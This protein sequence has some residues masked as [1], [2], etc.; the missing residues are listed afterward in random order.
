MKPSKQD[1]PNFHGGPRPT[2]LSPPKRGRQ[3]L[4]SPLAPLLFLI[5]FLPGLPA[6]A[7]ATM[8]QTIFGDLTPTVS[9]SD[10]PR[11]LGLRFSS[12]VAGQISAIRFYRA[13][14][15]CDTGAHTGYLYNAFGTQLAS[16]AIP[17]SN[18]TGWQEQALTTPVSITP[19]TVYVVAVDEFGCYGATTNSGLP[20][21]NGN[22]TGIQGVFSDSPSAFPATV[23]GNN[24]NYFRDV[25]FTPEV[26]ATGPCIDL[27]KAVSVNGPGGPFVR[28][29][30]TSVNPDMNAANPLI[31]SIPGTGNVPADSV[32]IP[33]AFFGGKPVF[34]QFEI[35]NCGTVDL[36]NVRLDDCID[37]RSVGVD[38]FLVGGVGAGGEG[39]CEQPRMIPASPQRIVT[40][41]LTPGQSVTVTSASFANDPINPASSNFIDICS[42]YGPARTSGIV[43]NDAEA[44]ADADTDGNGS[45]DKFVFFDDLN[46]VRCGTPPP[47]AKLGDRVWKDLNGNGIQDCTDTNNNGILG[48]AGDTGPECGEGVPDAVR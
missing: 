26:S 17:A 43:R 11:Q 1:P 4:A 38:G 8:G 10:T 36:Y 39:N 16:V 29:S 12:N 25:M 30:I 18:V 35:T 31:A 41:K 48:D 19:N 6:L 33:T 45:G 46:L 22:L 14:D 13:A 15:G 23:S 24:A 21:T 9:F 7:A 27:K 42:T 40:N 5:L 20:V 28:N 37:K 32:N 44:E 47:T 3:F 2:A 34:Y